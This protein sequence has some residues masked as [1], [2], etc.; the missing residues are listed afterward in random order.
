MREN[1]L[2]YFA[3]HNSL[4]HSKYFC[5]LVVQQQIFDAKNISE[6]VYLKCIE[7]LFTFIKNVYTELVISDTRIFL[8]LF[9]NFK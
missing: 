7:K 9:E 4:Q 6:N 5:A 3:A 1:S 8:N 2:G